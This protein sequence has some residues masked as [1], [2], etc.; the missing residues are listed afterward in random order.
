M[1]NNSLAHTKWECKYH[2]VFAPKYRRQVIYKDIKPPAKRVVLTP[3]Y[4]FPSFHT[5]LSRFVPDSTW[6]C[7]KRHESDVLVYCITHIS[8]NDLPEFPSAALSSIDDATASPH[9]SA[10]QIENSFCVIL[11]KVNDTVHWE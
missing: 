1:D 6:S 2:I 4:I 8:Q 11:L 5:C 3:K 10:L 9:S 7:R